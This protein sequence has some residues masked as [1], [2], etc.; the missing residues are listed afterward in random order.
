MR[1]RLARVFRRG[2]SS[3]DDHVRILSDIARLLRIASEEPELDDVVLFDR[4]VAA[5]VERGRAWRLVTFVPIAFGRTIIDALGID[6][7][8]TY[9]RRNGRGRDKR[10][11]L[12]DEPEFRA[13]ADH[14]DDFSGRAGFKELAV[15][16]AEVNAVNNALKA[17]SDAVDMRLIETV[18]WETPD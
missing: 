6:A 16:S 7:P 17:G 9:L 15:R 4:L 1:D 18:A 8:P 5:G 2:S 12:R 14:L 10:R 13:A 3:D 11:R